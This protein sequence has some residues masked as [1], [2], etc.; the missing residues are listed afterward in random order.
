MWRLTI[1]LINNEVINKLVIYFKVKSTTL[2]FAQ[3]NSKVHDDGIQNF[4]DC[5]FL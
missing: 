3:I 2:T 5:L 1:Q 4:T